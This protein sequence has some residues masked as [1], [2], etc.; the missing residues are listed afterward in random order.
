M[1]DTAWLPS[2][3]SDPFNPF[4]PVTFELS[5]IP[6]G[7]MPPEPRRCGK[8]PRSSEGRRGKEGHGMQDHLL[9]SKLVFR[10]YPLF[11]IDSR[12]GGE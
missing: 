1:S 11:P 8:I 10:S 6:D 5:V 3:P 9:L 4:D 7:M 12:S 2:D